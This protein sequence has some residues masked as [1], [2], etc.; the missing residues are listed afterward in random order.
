MR[1]ANVIFAG[2]FKKFHEESPEIESR[3]RG[4]F[5]EVRKTRFFFL[6]E[7]KEVS[8][9][10]FMQRLGFIYKPEQDEEQPA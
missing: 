2:L 1:F 3:K 7:K 5:R 9:I 4:K 8:A 10:D 6:G